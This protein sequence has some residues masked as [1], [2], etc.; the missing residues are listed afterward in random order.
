MVNF[1]PT[2][3]IT[4]TQ[5]HGFS[6]GV[7]VFFQPSDAATP[8]VAEM[9]QDIP[10]SIQ[11]LEVFGGTLTHRPKDPQ[12]TWSGMSYWK[13]DALFRIAIIGDP[14]GGD[15]GLGPGSVLIVNHVL[16]CTIEPCIVAI[17]P[18]VVP[19]ADG[20]IPVPPDG[21][22]YRMKVHVEVASVGG[23]WPVDSE[24]ELCGRWS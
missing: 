4:W 13:S 24:I 22:P 11:K 2:S 12:T 10:Y 14:A 7:E 1:T 21:G 20:A 23:G 6:M 3:G 8:A 18:F 9:V 15:G 17:P 16:K 5:N 19:C